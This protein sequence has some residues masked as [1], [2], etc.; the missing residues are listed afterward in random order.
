M[1][2]SDCGAGSQTSGEHEAA[3][4]ST[5]AAPSGIDD[6]FAVAFS[7]HRAGQIAAAED[8]Y[9]RILDLAPDHANALHRLGLLRHQQGRSE[10]AVTLISR[11]I[12]RD[13]TVAEFHYDLGVVLE[14]TKRLEEAA[15]Q[16]RQATVLNPSHADAY[17]KLANV[18]LAGNRLDEAESA[19]RRAVTLAPHGSHAKYALG[20]TLA[21]ARRFNEAIATLDHVVRVMPSHAAAHAELGA[22]CVAV[23]DLD[24]GA[25][26]CYR[27]LQLDPRNHQAAV[28][29]GLACLARG[30]I[31]KAM[32]L[33]LHAFDIED[34]PPARDLFARA[35][36]HVQVV[37][38]NSRFRA[39]VTRALAERW[40]RPRFLMR[41]A[42]SLIKL[43]PGIRA[44]IERQ[45][46]ATHRS[47][48][49]TDL[50]S[51]ADTAAIAHDRLLRA[52]LTVT[53]IC[54]IEL[55]RVLTEVRQHFLHIATDG[56]APSIGS[57]VLALCGA[58]AQQCFANE[59]VYVV[60]ENE[61]QRAETLGQMLAATVRRGDDVP[62]LW[63]AAVGAYMP[64]HALPD[65]ERLTERTWPTPVAAV[66]RQQ[67]REPAE[68]R[69]MRE[70]MPCLTSIQDA[71]SVAVRQHYEENPYP[72]W[73]AAAAAGP[74]QS[75]DAYIGEKFPRAAYVPL[76]RPRIDVLNAGCG[77]GQH[78]IETARRFAGA[79]VLA[80]D[81]STASLAYA[82]FKSREIGVTNISFAVADILKLSSIGR[83]FDVIEAQGVLHHMADPMAAWRKLL[84]ILRPGGLMSLGLYSAR[85][86]EPLV[87]ARAL[88][89]ARGYRPTADGIRRS[90][91]AIV[92]SDDPPIRAAAERVDFFTTS[93]CRD[94]L[95]HAH[96]HCLALPE[97]AA[98]LEM[99]DL[100]FLGFDIEPALLRRYEQR[101]PADRSHTDLTSWHLFETENPD[102]FAGMYRFWVQKPFT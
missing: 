59:Y 55:E 80:V 68:L 72:R 101:C 46:L 18:L 100:R 3:A 95:F 2:H 58:I 71:V 94:L 82:L 92:R 60:A 85:A 11:A 37:A 12:G 53:P 66:V 89:A 27:S 96:E 22:A 90:R 48:P 45:A 42:V 62:A 25:R 24:R 79:D 26:H 21:R 67:I 39:L 76:A 73:F 84:S 1:S 14:A 74:R 47:A 43:N 33:A 34:S 83:C 93:E 98:F 40:M 36:P 54:D 28:H 9:R 7:R 30:E 51:S 32:E 57:E 15:E 44:T 65:A 6:L 102:S 99:E 35:A 8:S 61:A 69:V 63:L 31:M 49:T 29:L 87:R 16:Y 97:I 64:L 77:T 23:G 91:L 70:S 20:A 50:P 4:A 41:P 5:A 56:S 17:L 78:A 38:E 13:G 75:L 10:E 52:L 86:R 81:L 19:C 88:I